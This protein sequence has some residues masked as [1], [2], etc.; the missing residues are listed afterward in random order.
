MICSM[1]LNI[2]GSSDLYSNLPERVWQVN[3]MIAAATEVSNDVTYNMELITS[4]TLGGAYQKGG[5][6]IIKADAEKAISSSN[7]TNYLKSHL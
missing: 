4:A 2:L 3:A 7:L 1:L 6:T 5:Y